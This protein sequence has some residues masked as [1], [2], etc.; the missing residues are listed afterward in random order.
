MGYKV[1]LSRL[2][3]IDLSVRSRVR[4]VDGSPVL[5]RELDFS[6]LGLYFHR[7]NRANGFGSLLRF[8]VPVN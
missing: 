8:A 3:F 5:G 1:D 7:H 6:M 4:I 2:A